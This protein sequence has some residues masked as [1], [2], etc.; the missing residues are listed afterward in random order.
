MDRGTAQGFS[1]K[2]GGGLMQR[3]MRK[4][5][6]MDY[7]VKQKDSS[8]IKT[9]I[10]ALRSLYRSARRM[11]CSDEDA[12]LLNFLV[13]DLINTTNFER[14]LLL[15]LDPSVEYLETYLGYGF[16]DT[17]I[18]GYR[19]PFN[20]LGGL[21]KRVYYDKEPVNVMH[22]S[23]LRESPCSSKFFKVY[24]EDL[25]TERD[26]ERRQKITLC[27]PGSGLPDEEM[28]RYSSIQHYSIMYLNKYDEI[29]G[30]LLG[31]IDAFMIIP[32]CDDK[33]FYGFVLAD[34]VES[35]QEITYDEIRLSSAVVKH[36]AFAI[37]RARKHQEMLIKIADQ[38]EEIQQIKSFYQSI[39]QNLRSGLV[40]LD[41]YLK[42]NS[43][44]R[45]AEMILGYDSRELLGKSLDFFLSYSDSR[46]KCFFLDTVD[47]VDAAM[48]MVLE[49]PMRRKNG[50]I[51][52]AE[53]CYSVITDSNNEISGLSCIFQDIT[54]RKNMEAHL[55]RVER[56]AS[57]G[58]LAAGVAH[59][60][61][62]PLAGIAGA[63]QVMSR[64]QDKDS[65]HYTIFKEVFDQVKRLDGFVTNLLKFARPR[66]SKF[67]NI[68]LEE[69][70]QKSLFMVHTQIENKQIKVVENY[71][72]NLP[73]IPGDAG[74]LQQVFINL[75]INAIDAMD[76]GG[77]LTI[78][79][80]LELKP[81][82]KPGNCSEVPKIKLLNFLAVEV[83]DTG[84]GIDSSS[85][86]MIFNPFYTTK[87]DGTG[88][89]LSI[90][91]R[92]IEQHGGSIT[93]E[94]TPGKGST[95]TVLLPVQS[96][97]QAIETET[98]ALRNENR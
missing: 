48:G 80:R 53:I 16:N 54:K 93:V 23:K 70:I 63:L 94:S 75:F 43:V 21:L 20:K 18:E 9:S 24:R 17:G 49:V 45:A 28:D 4:P 50:E 30:Y 3:I 77:T 56:L 95:F 68:Y 79:I 29:I 57:L 87:S 51:F 27:V 84:K 92:I 98:I 66:E 69:I 37:G 26:S 78:K 19:V 81:D 8:E 38:L 44:N 97:S 67:T 14:I 47:E 64:S 52:P 22:Y 62:N 46:H 36:A 39:I 58:E 34:K 71:E 73:K 33:S 89:G 65:K 86:E 82:H 10:K 91:H 60:I 42:I 25:D 6:W 32:I 2:G 40:T 12:V 7:K 61:R 55:A 5:K 88:L 13:E 35:G 96:D 11:A 72:E 41:Q 85:H 59:E 83:T 1:T 15:I 31:D 76:P 74:Q 90:S